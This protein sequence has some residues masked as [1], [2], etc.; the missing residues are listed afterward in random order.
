MG[1]NSG[2]NGERDEERESRVGMGEVVGGGV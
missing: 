1:W 2:M